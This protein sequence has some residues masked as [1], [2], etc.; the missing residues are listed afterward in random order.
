[1]RCGQFPDQSTC[2]ANSTSNLDQRIV[3]EA[4]RDGVLDT[5]VPALREYYR[6]KRSVMEEALRSELA[7]AVGWAEPRGGFFLWAT[8]PAPLQSHGLLPIALAH[9]VI[10][11]S[12][13]AF[14]VDGSGGQFVRLAFSLPTHD[15]IR[16]GVRRLGAALREALSRPRLQAQP[17]APQE[18]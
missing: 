17:A 16:E 12:G 4:I 9:G 6:A 14:F 15:Q 10:F 5:R 2:V 18:R 7:D 1:M 8:L 13:Q 11:V 3:Y